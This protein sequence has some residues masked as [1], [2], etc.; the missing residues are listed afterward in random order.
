MAASPTSSMMQ[1]LVQMQKQRSA[2]GS[3]LAPQ[4]GVFK[5]TA[6]PAARLPRRTTS[7]SEAQ[8]DARVDLFLANSGVGARLK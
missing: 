5:A 6:D 8:S 2:S 4:G 3:V 7:K 1:Q